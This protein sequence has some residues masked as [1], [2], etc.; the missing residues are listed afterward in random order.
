[1]TDKD[2]ALIALRAA[3]QAAASARH[4][5]EPVARTERS[6]HDGRDPVTLDS[7]VDALLAQRAWNLPATGRQVRSMWRTAARDLANHVR[8][9]AFDPASGR[10]ELH[11]D[12]GAYTLQTRLSAAILTQ[13]LNALL[14]TDAVRCLHVLPPDHQSPA[15]LPSADP[16]A[17]ATPPSSGYL[18]ALVALREGRARVGTPR[19]NGVPSTSGEPGD[20]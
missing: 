12:S 8:A 18:R 4:R 17:P 3:R 14:G 13:R 2:L 9:V 16:P 6:Q 11:A 20:K 1:M 5:P 19:R 15:R 10:L 7:A